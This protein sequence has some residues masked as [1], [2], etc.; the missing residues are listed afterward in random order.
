MEN[1]NLLDSKISRSLALT[2]RDSAYTHVKKKSFRI[3]WCTSP[4]LSILCQLPSIRKIL[5]LIILKFPELFF[6]L[7]SAALLA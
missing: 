2:P 4:K 7:F 6:C 5:I 3:Q 1:S